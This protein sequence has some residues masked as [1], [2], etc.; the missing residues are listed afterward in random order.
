[1]Y[2]TRTLSLARRSYQEGSLPPPC[3]NDRFV[4]A[5]SWDEILAKIRSI[6]A[7]ILRIIAKIFRRKGAAA[8]PRHSDVHGKKAWRDSE[9]A[10]R[11]ENEKWNED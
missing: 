10:S 2:P 3:H 4:K 9:R 1:L 5:V 8:L 11:K 6:L 7:K